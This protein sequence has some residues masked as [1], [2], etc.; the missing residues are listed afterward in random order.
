LRSWGCDGLGADEQD[1]V[2]DLFYRGD[3]SLTR[4]WYEFEIESYAD[5]EGRQLTGA[6]SADSDAW[7]RAVWLAK[8]KQ[9]RARRGQPAEL[10]EEERKA[11]EGEALE[12]HLR[13]AKLE[14]EGRR[15]E[16]EIKAARSSRK[17]LLIVAAGGTFLAALLY[18]GVLQA[19]FSEQ[20][21]KDLWAWSVMMMAGGLVGGGLQHL[22]L[23]ALLLGTPSARRL[24]YA[25]NGLVGAFMGVAGV[26]FV[27]LFFVLAAVLMLGPGG[28][29]IDEHLFIAVGVVIGIMATGALLGA[30]LG[31]RSYRKGSGHEIGLEVAALAVAPFLW[32]GMGVNFLALVVVVSAVTFQAID[33]NMNLA[34]KIATAVAAFSLMI[35]SWLR[36]NRNSVWARQALATALLALGLLAAVQVMQTFGGTKDR[37]ST[38][39]TII[40]WAAD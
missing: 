26:I 9:T 3:L 32:V 17:W 8:T 12:L 34:L 5:E 25:A 39:P 18:S 13:E 38:G 10:T 21:I 2:L 35:A 33:G 20:L 7:L 15:R 24:S 14:D 28:N 1:R 36:R 37:P 29:F 11:S 6:K 16:D 27:G 30:Y 19:W 40:T 23:R 31:Y 4:D 22:Q